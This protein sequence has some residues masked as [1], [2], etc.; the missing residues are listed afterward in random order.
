MGRAE[1]EL[2]RA[3]GGHLVHLEAHALLELRGIGRHDCDFISKQHGPLENA[4]VH[5]GLKVVR[6]HHLLWENLHEGPLGLHKWRR[7]ASLSWG[8]ETRHSCRGVGAMVSDF[9]HV[10]TTLQEDGGK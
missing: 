7:M 2:E 1:G 3:R 8:W 6:R 9:S 5:H 10:P 4:V